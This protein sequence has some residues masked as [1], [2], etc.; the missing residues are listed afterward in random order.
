MDRIKVANLIFA[1]VWAK[2]NYH[3][4]GEDFSRDNE[5]DVWNKISAPKI[6]LLREVAKKVWNI[7]YE[8]K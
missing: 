7:K 4:L 5:I 2:T 1:E 6:P 8:Q 3:M